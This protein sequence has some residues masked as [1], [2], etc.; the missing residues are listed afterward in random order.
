LTAK[1]SESTAQPREDA[2]FGTRDVTEGREPS[3]GTNLQPPKLPGVAHHY[4]NVNGVRLHYAEAGSGDPV[5]LLHGWPQHWWMWRELIGPLAE[6][7]RVICPD[8]RG[9]G[10]SDAPASD[11]GVS[12]LTED[13]LGVLDHLGI[14]RARVVGHDVGLGVGYWMCL[15]HTRRVERYVAMSAWHLWAASDLRLGTML[16][17]WHMALLA[18]PLGAFAVRRLGMPER[19]L[20]RWRRLGSFSTEEIEIYL[21][22]LRRPGAAKATAKRYRRG[23]AEV[24]WFSRHYKRLRVNVP[25]LHLVGEKD[26]T[27]DVRE[28]EFLHTHAADLLFETVPGA[29]HFLPEERPDWIRERLLEFFEARRPA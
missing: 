15:F 6:H 23:L 2:V 25:T 24:M 27:I 7:Y 13:V 16:R 29:G 20:R 11:Y 17:P 9:F 14:D 12:R 22:P 3:R 21:G 4:V 28:N 18:S 26:P 8:F 5:V 1:R 19:A 10:W